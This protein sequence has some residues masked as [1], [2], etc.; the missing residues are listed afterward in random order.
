MKQARDDVAEAANTEKESRPARIPTA[1]WMT[2][3]AA[4]GAIAASLGIS[5]L[6]SPSPPIPTEHPLLRRTT[7]KAVRKHLQGFG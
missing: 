3:G 5:R 6:Q 1:F 2:A 4:L 7:T